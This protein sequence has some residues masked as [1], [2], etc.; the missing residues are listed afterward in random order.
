MVAKYI[1]EVW[2][3]SF[4][5]PLSPTKL[6]GSVR[7]NCHEN[8]GSTPFW[9]MRLSCEYVRLCKLGSKGFALVVLALCGEGLRHLAKSGS[10]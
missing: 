6:V 9:S 10:L 7:R 8:E 5:Y 4:P 3:T 2:V 1:N